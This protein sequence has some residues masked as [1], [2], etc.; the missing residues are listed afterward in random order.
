MDV[1]RSWALVWIGVPP[2]PMHC[3]SEW[4]VTQALHFFVQLQNRRNKQQASAPPLLKGA[5]FQLENALEPTYK[6]HP[7]PCAW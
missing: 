5:L 2:S 7:T 1:R 4:E 3:K 6:G